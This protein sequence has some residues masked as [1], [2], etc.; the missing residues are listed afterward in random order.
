MATLLT[1]KSG[2]PYV[3]YY[4]GR[5][6]KTITLPLRFDKKTA[7]ELKQTVERAADLLSGQCTAC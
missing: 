4:E 5:N 3:Q 7:E 1:T 6:R 2:A